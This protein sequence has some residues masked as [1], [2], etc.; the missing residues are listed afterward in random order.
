MTD[1]LK[2]IRLDHLIL[3]SRY[4]S[5]AI[6]FLVGIVVAVVAKTPELAIAFPLVLSAPFISTYF[7]VYEKN[8]L[9][10]LYGILPLGRKEAVI[11]IYCLAL[12][13]VVVDAII[14]GVFTYILS[15]VLNMPMNQVEFAAYVSVGFFYFCLVIA[16]LF[17]LYFKFSFSKI[18]VVSNLPFYLVFVASFLIVKKTDWLA[19]LAQVLQYFT[20]HVPMI[21]VTGFGAGLVLLLISLPLAYQ[22]HRRADL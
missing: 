12:L 11:G 8:G 9:S 10:R 4:G 21:W 22:I 17:P 2:A 16:V 7:S 20:S 18:Y 14:A 19:N 5:F 1:V 3:R 13:I 6:I 15:V